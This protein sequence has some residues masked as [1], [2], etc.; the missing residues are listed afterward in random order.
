MPP[1]VIQNEP[2]VIEVHITAV[3][4]KVEVPKEIYFHDE[5]D[6]FLALQITKRVLNFDP[7]K[8]YR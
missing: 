7:N 6:N 4:L 5:Q 2:L 8:I 3:I 1:C